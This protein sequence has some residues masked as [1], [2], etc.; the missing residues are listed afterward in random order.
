M[1]TKYDTREDGAP[2]H[3]CSVGWCRGLFVLYRRTEEGFFSFH[4]WLFFCFQGYIRKLLFLSSVCQE[5]GSGLGNKSRVLI[6]ALPVEKSKWE[7]P[8]VRILSR[9]ATSDDY[10]V[11][12][13]SM[14]F[15]GCGP[16]HSKVMFFKTRI[17][18][19]F[20]YITGHYIWL[21]E[22]YESCG[23]APKG[24]RIMWVKPSL[25]DFLGDWEISFVCLFC[26]LP[27]SHLERV[28]EGQRKEEYN[29]IDEESGS[30]N[31]GLEN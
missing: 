5:R 13:G 2:Y 12:G 14:N 23:R 24:P 4:F 17:C 6:L 20:T 9:L 16:N 10:L 30:E 3:T 28:C 15:V 25:Q 22:L 19:N 7:F 8:T 29:R 1:N 11:K 18:S 27:L 31:S 21:T 26:S